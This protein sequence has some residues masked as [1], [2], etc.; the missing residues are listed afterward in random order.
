MHGKVGGQE[1]VFE[2]GWPIFELC[3]LDHIPE[4]ISLRR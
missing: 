2:F 3:K 1:A 4:Q